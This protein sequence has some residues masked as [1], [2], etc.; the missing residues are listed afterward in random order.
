MLVHSFFFGEKIRYC[1]NPGLTIGIT[2]IN[3][4]YDSIII[5]EHNFCGAKII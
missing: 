2:V 1:K 3:L 5:T 4:I